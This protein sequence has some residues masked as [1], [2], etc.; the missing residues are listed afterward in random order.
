ML[1]FQAI[2]SAQ[3]SG[4]QQHSGDDSSLTFFPKESG[5]TGSQ[6]QRSLL[7]SRRI[8]LR[9]DQSDSSGSEK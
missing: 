9:T 2:V 5:R 6:Q 3:G 1:L 8:G 7:H 4:L